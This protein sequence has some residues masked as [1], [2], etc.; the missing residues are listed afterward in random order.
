MGGFLEILIPR[1]GV[2]KTGKGG[3]M[4]ELYQTKMT[5]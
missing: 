2:R 3:K 5:I 1:T 4:N